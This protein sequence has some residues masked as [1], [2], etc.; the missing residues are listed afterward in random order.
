MRRE[1]DRLFGSFWGGA[2]PTSGSGVFPA[3]NVR[4]DG[5]KYYVEAEI[6]GIK[7]EDIDIAVEGNTL[8]I[9][10]ERKSDG[11]ENAGYH[12][13]ERKA[14]KFQKALTLPAE[15]NGEAVG[16]EYKEGVLRVVLPKAEH[17]KPKKITVKSE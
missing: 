2:S 16:A 14:G 3:F 11:M 10:G 5:E 1:M 17:A 6:P 7:P 15:V 13:R 12:R 4:E 8:T 9:R